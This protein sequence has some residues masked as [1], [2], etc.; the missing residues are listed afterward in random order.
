MTEAH[1]LK[2][3]T[4]QSNAF[5]T[6]FE[7]LKEILHDVNI[8]FDKDGMK[9]MTVDGSHVALVHLKLDASNFETYECVEPIHV[10]INMTNLHKLLKMAGNQD[11]I[12]FTI[13]KD[14]PA[15]LKIIIDNNEKKTIT[16]FYLKL[17]DVDIEELNMPDIDFDSV[18]TLPSAYFQ[19]L[20]KDM[21]NIAEIL[22]I[23]SSRNQ[24]VLSCK[25][26]FASQQTV[27]QDALGVVEGATLHNKGE[28]VSGDYMLK[29]LILFNKA[30]N[31]SNTME[32]YMRRDYPLVLKYNVANLGELRFCLAPKVDDN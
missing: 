25:G 10:G 9:I 13:E 3:R 27:I 23:H 15:E 32:L 8:I 4:V 22:T 20:C 26:D 1:V 30:S 14:K 29:Y 21:N 6:L 17:M 19:R 16:T 7:V 18:I 28:D 31:L 24:L 5:K 12:T 11:T 2:L